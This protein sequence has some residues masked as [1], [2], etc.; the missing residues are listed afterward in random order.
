MIKNTKELKSSATCRG[1]E[2]ETRTLQEP[3]TST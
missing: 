1:P 2:A 3:E